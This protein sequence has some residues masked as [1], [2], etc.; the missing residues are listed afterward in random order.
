MNI[1]HDI[2]VSLCSFTNILYI[3]HDKYFQKCIYH[4]AI[5]IESKGKPL[6]SHDHELN[7]K[8]LILGSHSCTFDNVALVTLVNSK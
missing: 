3:Y 1:S 2:I 5:A 7:I 8:F 4:K 6:Q